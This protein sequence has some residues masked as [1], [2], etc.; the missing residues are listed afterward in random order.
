MRPGVPVVL[1]APDTATV[2][3]GWKATM[4]LEFGEAYRKA[5]KPDAANLPEGEEA[6]WH[7]SVHFA[8]SQVTQQSDLVVRSLRPENCVQLDDTWRSLHSLARATAALALGGTPAVSNTDCPNDSGVTDKPISFL[9]R[10][11]RGLATAPVT[12]RPWFRTISA[13]DVL[14]LGSKIDWADTVVVVGQDN[15]TSTEDR[16][17]T[18]LGEMPGALL[19]ANALAGLLQAQNPTHVDNFAY[20]LLELRLL[21]V[22]AAT[23]VAYWFASRGVRRLVAKRTPTGCAGSDPHVNFTAFLL[24]LLV[25]AGMTCVA[26]V[27]VEFV[28]L[29]SGLAALARGEFGLGSLAPIVGV[30]LEALVEVGGLLTAWVERGAAAHVAWVWRRG[31]LGWRATMGRGRADAPVAVLLLLLGFGSAQ[32]AN[33]KPEDTPPVALLRITGDPENVRVERP[34][35]GMLPGAEVL[36]LFAYDT[37]R[38]KQGRT[39]AR[40]IYFSNGERPKIAET[41]G[42]AGWEHVVN[43]QPPS[44]ES[45]MLWRS[46]RDLIDGLQ[47]PA[48]APR[49]P[50]AASL[51]GIS[52]LAGST[53]A[54][55]QATS[56]P[57]RIEDM[58]AM[59]ADTSGSAP[60]RGEWQIDLGSFGDEA[61]ARN[62]ATAARMTIGLRV[63]GILI[64]PVL[65]GEARQYRARLGDLDQLGALE[66]CGK[67]RPRNACNVISPEE[68]AAAVVLPLRHGAGLDGG[69][70]FIAAGAV[71][72]PLAWSGGTGPFLVQVLGPKG[73]DVLDAQT[74]RG[75]TA[76]V[77]ATALGQ[78]GQGRIRIIDRADDSAIALT[79]TMAPQ[80][81]LAAGSLGKA[82]PLPAAAYLYGEAQGWRIEGLRR[83]MDLAAEGDAD[84]QPILDGILAR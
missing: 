66:A 4:R 82:L 3:R 33:P 18:P 16:F 27:V 2:G 53:T 46:L 61:E 42:R 7:D 48:A 28:A 32:A 41:D 10:P 17:E 72:F 25:F 5:A 14:K 68:A 47:R 24:E 39:T 38:V 31:S 77:P 78:A 52:N 62:A 80:P 73:E 69:N 55:R 70:Y 54:A 76:R 56:S 75:R 30:A 63:A 84:A 45:W 81:K 79:V 51:A 49:Q 71:D 9:I 20:Y 13:A 19:Q 6:R 35:K 64:A 43:A 12:A 65:K 60:A 1:A 34:K 67:L 26:I 37:V 11:E 29:R 50:K 44:P 22:T 21:L 40:V 36:D 15:A 8:S 74:V 59:S 58:I 83:F 57:R 23:G